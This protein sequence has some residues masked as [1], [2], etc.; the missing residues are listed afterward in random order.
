MKTLKDFTIYGYPDKKTEPCSCSNDTER[1]DEWHEKNIC[2]KSSIDLEDLK[3]AAREWI[4]KLEKNL[5]KGRSYCLICLAPSVHTCYERKHSIL[6]L[7]KHEETEIQGA[8]KWIT[9]FFNLE[10]SK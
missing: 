4:E 1:I 10:E 7:A 5:Y 8:I 3:Q 9:E 2:I 6:Y